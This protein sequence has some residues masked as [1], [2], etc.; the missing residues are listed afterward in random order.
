MSMHTKV[1]P[2]TPLLIEI[3]KND[4]DATPPFKF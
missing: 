1:E 4:T 3:L 2:A